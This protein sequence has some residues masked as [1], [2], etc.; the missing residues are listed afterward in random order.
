MVD[1]LGDDQPYDVNAHP[2]GLQQFLEIKMRKLANKF[3]AFGLYRGLVW[4]NHTKPYHVMYS[5]WGSKI[6][7][8]NFGGHFPLKCWSRKT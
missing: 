6:S 4:G 8:S 5:G 2:S 1:V 3:D 7:V